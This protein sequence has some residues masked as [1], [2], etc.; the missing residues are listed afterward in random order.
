MKK[1]TL[2]LIGVVAVAL[3]AAVILWPRQSQPQPG[4]TGG[5]RATTSA[6][7]AGTTRGGSV[8]S[9]ASTKTGSGGGDQRTSVPVPDWRTKADQSGNA[10]KL[11]SGKTLASVNGKTITAADL[12]AGG[13]GQLSPHHYHVL[14]QRAIER[15]L[16]VRAAAKASV[17]LTPQQEQQLQKQFGMEPK[18]DPNIFT[19][20][21]RSPADADF[22]LRDQAAKMLEANLAAQ[23]GAPSPHV[24]QED[25]N[26][27][28]N[29]H[30]EE[31]A[32]ANSPAK[33]RVV[34]EKLMTELREKYDR[35]LQQYLNELRAGAQVTIMQD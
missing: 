9:S 20:Q 24:T 35:W 33:Q 12:V 8:G 19:N 15:E 3:V 10:I 23:A 27:Y 29:A 30:P 6:G 13:Q 32:G 1:N 31:A 18:R 25:V 14:L 16:V 2:L 22:Y 21:E 7:G 34:R 11:L 5:D 26:A 17:T 28:L 4:A